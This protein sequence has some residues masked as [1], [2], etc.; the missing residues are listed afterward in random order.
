MATKPQKA[1]DTARSS[2]SQENRK[3]KLLK[4]IKLQPNNANLPLALG[5]IYYRRKKPNKPMWSH[6][7]IAL[8][9]LFKLFNGRVDPGIFSSNPKV[10]AAAIAK[11]S[12]KL[13]D[14]LP[15][16][17]VDFS[18]GARAYIANKAQAV[19]SL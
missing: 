7:N 2:R 12:T 4:Q 1:A 16:G 11:P 5:N 8:A 14:N 19:G 10:Q 3:R 17:K 18:L 6:S 9:K 15:Q 13:F